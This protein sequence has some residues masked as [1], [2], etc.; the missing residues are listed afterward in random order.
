[1]VDAPSLES[2]KVRLDRALTHLI[3]LQQRGWSRW[4]IK[5][6]STSKASVIIWTPP[7]SSQRSPGSSSSPNKTCLVKTKMHSHKAIEGM[8][9]DGRWLSRKLPRKLILPFHCTPALPR[10]NDRWSRMKGCH[11]YPPQ[12]HT[13][14]FSFHLKVPSAT[15]LERGLQE[16]DSARLPGMPG[17]WQ[18]MGTRTPKIYK[19][20]GR[21]FRK[22]EHSCKTTG[23]RNGEALSVAWQK[24]DRQAQQKTGIHSNIF[25]RKSS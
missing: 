8:Q 9:W 20:K 21:D 6:S 5:V 12:G 11:L 18:E 16:Q 23:R 3:H 19:Q 17:T 1:M 25:A 4:P 15:P 13:C 2:F 7:C 10:A 22:Q 14:W 24:P